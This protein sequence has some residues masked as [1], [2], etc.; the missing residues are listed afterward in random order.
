[1]GWRPGDSGE[2]RRPQG[3]A[4]LIQFVFGAWSLRMSCPGLI[5]SQ[6]VEFGGGRP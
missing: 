4:Q 3:G 6:L 1:M 2:S 5:S